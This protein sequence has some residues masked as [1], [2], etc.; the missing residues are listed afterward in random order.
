MSDAAG[1]LTARWKGHRRHGR[2]TR[3]ESIQS[4]LIASSTLTRER[5]RPSCWKLQNKTFLRRTTP[6]ATS[7]PYRRTPT[8]SCSWAND[9]GV[10]DKPSAGPSHE[11]RRITFSGQDRG[12]S[13]VG[14]GS[15]SAWKFDWYETENPKGTWDRKEL[16]FVEMFSGSG[17]P[18][19][20]IN[21]YV[22]AG[23]PRN[24]KE[25]NQIST[26]TR[27]KSLSA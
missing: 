22:R 5:Q 23:Q 21:D 15:Q 18:S 1:M 9:S 6:S 16:H 11:I 10:T 20:P 24:K 14:P 2:S 12:S 8:A 19:V 7:V 17:Q 27:T 3:M 25:E 26:S 13:F 4:F